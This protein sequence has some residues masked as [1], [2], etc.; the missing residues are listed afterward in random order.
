MHL[1]EH[2]PIP[3]LSAYLK[4]YRIID[5]AF[6][7]HDPIQKADLVPHTWLQLTDKGKLIYFVQPAGKA[8]EFFRTMNNLPEL[9]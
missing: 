5:F 8:E 3:T 9:V 1:S 2:L 4:C 7:H 6:P